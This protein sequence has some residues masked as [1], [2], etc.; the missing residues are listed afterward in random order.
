MIK[1]LKPLGNKEN[2]ILVTEKEHRDLLVMLF[3]PV[4]DIDSLI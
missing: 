1:L 2:N 3:T 4:I